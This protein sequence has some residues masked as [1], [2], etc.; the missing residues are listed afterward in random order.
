LRA[1]KID[2]DELR[3]II[4]AYKAQILAATTSEAATRQGLAIANSLVKTENVLPFIQNDLGKLHPRISAQKADLAKWDTQLATTITD[5]E[6]LDKFLAEFIN[7][8]A[9]DVNKQ[10]FKDDVPGITS[11]RKE[12]GDIKAQFNDLQREIQHDLVN[13]TDAEIAAAAPKT[14]INKSVNIS[15]AYDAATGQ[16]ALKVDVPEVTPAIDAAGVDVQSSTGENYKRHKDYASYTAASAVSSN[17]LLKNKTS[18]ADRFTKAQYIMLD[19]VASQ[20][21]ERQINRKHAPVAAQPFN[22]RC[23]HAD[24]LIFGILAAKALGITENEL[25]AELERS[26]KIIKLEPSVIQEIYAKSNL[27]N[28]A[29]SKQ[30]WELQQELLHNYK[31]KLDVALGAAAHETTSFSPLAPKVAN[32]ILKPEAHKKPAVT[33]ETGSWQQTIKQVGLHKQQLDPIV[34]TDNDAQ[35]VASEM[36]ANIKV[37]GHKG[38]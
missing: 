6:N 9:D 10:Y 16:R 31:I 13:A 27:A 17:E 33:Y 34:K 4:D 21:V 18:V 20:V 7:L 35:K 37:I 12:L 38:P 23:T 29:Y 19:L 5:I 36:E 1:D 3:T 24:E 30:S 26:D 22:I 11:L 8:Q 32:S 28:H 14:V 15:H 2:L 25:S